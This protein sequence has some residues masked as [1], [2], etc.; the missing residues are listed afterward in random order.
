MV[1]KQFLMT[2]TQ[3]YVNFRLQLCTGYQY[4]VDVQVY[5]V[6]EVEMCSTSQKSLN[7]V[8]KY[9]WLVFKTTGFFSHGEFTQQYAGT[10]I[11]IY[12]IQYLSKV[13][14]HLLIQGFFF[15]FTIFYIVE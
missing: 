14:T 5:E 3:V 1:E 8:N 6:I 15:I 2:P 4:R 11:A 13:W 12:D 10:V 9:T 7:I